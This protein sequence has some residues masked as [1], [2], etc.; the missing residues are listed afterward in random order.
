M[1]VIELDRNSTTSLHSQI[2]NELAQ[3]IRSG[4]VHNGAWIP[5]TRLLAK[6]LGVSRNTVFAAYD[7]LAA[8]G[9]IIGR[10]G[11]GMRVN[12]PS[13]SSGG[14]LSG[15][16]KMIDAAHYPARTLAFE[17]ADGNALYFRLGSVR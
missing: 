6:L 5:S 10:G 11:S 12:A 14:I 2:H 1:P 15:L 4:S 9:L 7:E 17:D 13:S 16:R 3:A 8:D